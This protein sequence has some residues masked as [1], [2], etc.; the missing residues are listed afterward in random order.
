MINAKK[1]LYTPSFGVTGAPDGGEPTI[2]AGLGKPDEP[3]IG[4]LT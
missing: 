3:R 1:S 2:N 4:E